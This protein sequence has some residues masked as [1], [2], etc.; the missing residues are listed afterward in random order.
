MNNLGDPYDSLDDGSS[1][2]G[3]EVVYEQREEY[4]NEKRLYRQLAVIYQSIREHPEGMIAEDIVQQANQIL[5]EL[6]SGA[7]D[8]T[9]HV[10]PI[11]RLEER[12]MFFVT[13][14]KI[15]LLSALEAI[16]I[17]YNFEEPSSII[18]RYM[19]SNSSGI[20][21]KIDNRSSSSSSSNQ[22]QSQEQSV[23]IT[24][25]QV[26]KLI[27]NSLSAE[28]LEEIKPELKNYKGNPKK[29]VFVQK[30]ILKLL[31]FGITAAPIISMVVEFFL[32]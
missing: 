8:Y 30:L 3:E 7:H 22:S 32:S 16:A 2:S 11:N 5:T 6:S 23:K 4:P 24:I 18:G 15:K 27:E 1:L 14:L 29:W 28:Q 17:D 26:E 21:Q 13:Q 12:Q 10:Y 20:V 19:Q 9:P 31:A 25:E